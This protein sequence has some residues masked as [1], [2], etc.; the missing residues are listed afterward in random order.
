[1]DMIRGLGALWRGLFYDQASL[2]AAWELVKDWSASERETLRQQIPQQGMKATVRGHNVGVLCEQ[3]VRI[4]MAGERSLG[5]T[6]GVRLLEPL[7]QRAVERR[8]PADDILDA[9]ASVGGNPR[10]F[11]EKIRYR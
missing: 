11:V 4:A 2:Q 9:F 1:M 5:A 7:L 8:S 6:A 10:A 3:M